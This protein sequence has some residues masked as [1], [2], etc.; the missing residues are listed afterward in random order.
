MWGTV[1]DGKMGVICRGPCQLYLQFYTYIIELHSHLPRVRF[2]MDTYVIV[3]YVTLII[4]PLLEAPAEGFFR[5]APEFGHRIRFDV[6]HGCETCPLEAHFRRGDSVLFSNRSPAIIML[7]SIWS[8]V[9]CL[10]TNFALTRFIFKSSDR[11]AWMDPWEIPTFS[12]SV[13]VVLR[14]DRISCRTFS[15][16]FSVLDVEG[17][18]L[19]W[20]SSIDS[21]PFLN[22]ENQS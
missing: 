14:S 20:S 10:G 9:G 12:Y 17:L 6:L 19:P 11:N 1:S 3:L 8:V 16:I 7:H 18:P 22:R 5:S 4:L 21:W 13:V 15:I 2:L